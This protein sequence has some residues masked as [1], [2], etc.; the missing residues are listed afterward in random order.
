VFVVCAAGGWVL[1]QL[2]AWGLPV[3]DPFTW[4]PASRQWRSSSSSSSGDDEEQQ[5]AAAA[6]SSTAIW[7]DTQVSS[8][9]GA[10]I[11]RCDYVQ[12]S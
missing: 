11:E 2:P 10:A 8:L 12:D 1:Q 3:T 5:T 6:A 4:Q 9:T 7:V